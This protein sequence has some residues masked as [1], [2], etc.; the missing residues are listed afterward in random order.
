MA[1][2]LDTQFTQVDSGGATSGFADRF[3]TVGTGSNRALVVVITMDSQTPTGFT[4]T[5]DFGGTNQLMTQIGSATNGQTGGNFNYVTIFGLVNPTPGNNLL[6]GSWTGVSGND[7]WGYA[8]TGADQ[9]GGSTT[10]P[11]FNS[12]IG[13]DAS[14]TVVITSAVGNQTVAIY[15]DPDQV[16]NSVNGTSGFID[17]TAAGNYATGSDYMAGAA[18]VTHSAALGG[19]SVGWVAIGCSIAAAGGVT[20]PLIYASVFSTG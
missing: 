8:F 13:A 12:A 11:N 7:V 19:S 18:S 16:F 20:P 4:V 2:V 9:T 17:N 3:L 1:V 6:S 15:S 14:P 10:F 5:W